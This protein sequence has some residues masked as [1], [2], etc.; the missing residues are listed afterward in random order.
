MIFWTCQIYMQFHD[1]FRTVTLI[2][3]RDDSVDKTDSMENIEYG[4]I[5]V[6]YRD[7]IYIEHIYIYH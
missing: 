1:Q 2:I 3:K 5:F 7:N 4:P 6:D